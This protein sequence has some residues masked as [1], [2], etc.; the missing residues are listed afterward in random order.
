MI[1]EIVLL[2]TAVI[3]GLVTDHCIRISMDGKSCWRYKLFIARLWRSI[4]Y[5]LMHL[6]RMNL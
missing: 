6:P 2:T 1:G 4:K 3:T 5:Q